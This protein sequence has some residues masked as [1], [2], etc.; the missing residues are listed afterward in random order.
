MAA[1]DHYARAMA[2]VLRLNKDDNLRAQQE[3]IRAARKPGETLLNYQE[4]RI[5]LLHHTLDKYLTEGETSAS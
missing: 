1:Y 4:V 2:L 5:R 3:G